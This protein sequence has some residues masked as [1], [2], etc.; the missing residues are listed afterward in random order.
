MS[1]KWDSL[2]TVSPVLDDGW[3]NQTV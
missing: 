3:I 2:D 1:L